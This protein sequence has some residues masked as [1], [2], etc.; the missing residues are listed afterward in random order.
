MYKM[1]H[2]CF[3][4]HFILVIDVRAPADQVLG[5]LQVSLRA[6]AL[7]R[8]VTS[9]E[10]GEKKSP[11][12][13]PGREKFFFEKRRWTLPVWPLSVICQECF[14]SCRILFFALLRE[15]G[16]CEEKRRRNVWEKLSIV[17]L[18]RSSQQRMQ[19][20]KNLQKNLASPTNQSA[21]PLKKRFPM[22]F[23]SR[24]K[25]RGLPNIPWAIF[26]FFSQLSKGKTAAI[27]RWPEKKKIF[28]EKKI[29]QKLECRAVSQILN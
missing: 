2:Y 12:E 19:T 26:A 24:A 3:S 15:E 14:S 10:I 4:H 1:Y 25:E 11:N 6:C 16:R 8:G 29:S 27:M 22:E 23:F 21:S 17:I 9:L 13:W 18:I 7:Q 5:G 28:V 20:Q